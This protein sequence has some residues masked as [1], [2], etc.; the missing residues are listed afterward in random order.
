M[1]RGTYIYIYSDW[2]CTSLL[3]L[4]NRCLW[5]DICR[6]LYLHVNNIL[7]VY[8]RIIG[9]CS[10][11]EILQGNQST[12]HSLRSK[13]QDYCW[14]RPSQYSLLR[15][16]SYFSAST[17]CSVPKATICTSMADVSVTPS[18][19]SPRAFR[20]HAVWTQQPIEPVYRGQLWE[21]ICM[22]LNNAPFTHTV[23]MRRN[24]NAGL[25]F[26]CQKWI[27]SA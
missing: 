7:L 14:R 13:P 20:G 22:A 23:N 5:T 3:W 27:C 6:K 26:C 18:S 15:L 12:T 11:E 8:G 1:K 10:L 16:K 2:F 9:R 24:M 19:G 17:A 21:V 25:L 4:C